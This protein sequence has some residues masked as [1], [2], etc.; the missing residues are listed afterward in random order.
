MERNKK[1][2]LDFLAGNGKYNVIFEPFISRM[3]A[4]GLMWR[5]GDNLWNTVENL[6]DT[7]LFLAERVGE[8]IIFLDIRNQ[9]YPYK[10]DILNAISKKA[11][12]ADPI[13]FGI[14]CDSQDD[15]TLSERCSGVSAVAVYGKASSDKLPVIRM[16]GNIEDAISLGDSG[17]FVQDSVEEYLDKYG[18]QIRFLGGLGT[19]WIMSMPPVTIYDR[20]EEIAKKYPSKWA[21][22]S[23]GMISDDNY[24]ELISLLGAFGRIR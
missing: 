20:V 17:I 23:G 9:N 24:L 19:E 10:R 3:L 4:E 15:V 21:C 2:F 8:D 22:G 1:F 11:D 6:V 16:D 14:I 13:G 18:N 5:R 7:R 12:E